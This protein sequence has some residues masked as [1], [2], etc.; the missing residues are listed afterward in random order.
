MV[1][2]LLRD[3]SFGF[4]SCGG[5]YISTRSKHNHMKYNNKDATA[6]NHAPYAKQVQR[7]VYV[8]GGERRLNNSVLTELWS[9]SNFTKLT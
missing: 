1:L 2:L 9:Y 6:R 4:T 5:L 8:P 7:V 3:L